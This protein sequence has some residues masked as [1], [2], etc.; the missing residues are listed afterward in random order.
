[1]VEKISWVNKKT[2]NNC[3]INKK[4]QECVEINHFTNG[5]KNVLELQKK[6][7]KEFKIENE[8]EVLVVCNGAMGIN[9]LIG[10]LNLYY[11]KQ[12]KWVVQSFTFPCS[13]Q[14]LLMNSVIMDIDKNMGP[15]IE[16][17]EREKAN[18]DGILITNCFGCSVNIE[19]YENFCA[20]YDKLLLFDNAAASMTFYNGKNHLNYG[21][22]C[23]VSLHHTK[24]I[25]FG[26]GGFLVIDKK[27]IECMKRIICFGYTD[28]NKYDYSIYASNYKMSEISAIYITDY[29]ENLEKIFNHHTKMIKYFE[30][31]IMENGLEKQIELIKNYSPYEKSLMATIPILFKDNIEIVQFIDNH[32]EAKKYYYP[33]NKECK[34]SVDMY[35]RIICLPL[36]LDIDENKINY[37]VEIIRKITNIYYI[38]I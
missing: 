8:K 16:Q 1:M 26:E 33:L 2:I 14:G 18:F 27:Y 19:I 6:I 17:L 21:I 38:N 11:N 36:N 9:T 37:Y 24:P 15:D 12:L 28:T 29:L 32:I 3:E 23:M 35:A 5:G 13:T 34:N 20:K 7:K 31:K 25:G 4:I 30:L 22:G 10:G